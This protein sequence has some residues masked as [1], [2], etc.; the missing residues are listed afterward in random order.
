MWICRTRSIGCVGV[1]QDTRLNF[2]M[3]AGLPDV[4]VAGP[5]MPTD[6]HDLPRI[7]P[8]ASGDAAVTSAVLHWMARNWEMRAYL[9]YLGCVMEALRVF[10]TDHKFVKLRR[11]GRA[12]HG[13]AHPVR[14]R[15]TCLAVSTLEARKTYPGLIRAGSGSSTARTPT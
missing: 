10:R 14:G 5:L 1:A 13:V 4:D 8:K 3:L 12:G 15:V 6:W 11:S 2:D 7:G 9:R